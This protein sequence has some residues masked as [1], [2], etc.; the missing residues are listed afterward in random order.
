MPKCGA[1]ATVFQN[2]RTLL[3][4]QVVRNAD[5]IRYDSNEGMCHVAVPRFPIPLIPTTSYS[6]CCLPHESDLDHNLDTAAVTPL[7]VRIAWYTGPAHTPI[8]ATVSV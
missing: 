1:A 2:K 6:C 3:Q 7:T 4:K 8:S 5:Q